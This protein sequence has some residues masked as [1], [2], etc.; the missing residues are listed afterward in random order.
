[1]KDTGVATAA[2]SKIEE[3]TKKLTEI[4]V[5]DDSNPFDDF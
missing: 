4:N 5:D 3:L 2:K 1:L